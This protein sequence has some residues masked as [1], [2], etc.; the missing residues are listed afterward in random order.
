M[1]E[2]DYGQLLVSDPTTIFYLTGRWIH[3]GE[4]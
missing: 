3:P 4:R 2:Q 1:N